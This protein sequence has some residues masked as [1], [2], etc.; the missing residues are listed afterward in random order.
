MDHYIDIKLMPDAEMPENVLMNK[1]Y[2]KLHKVL[3]DF[4]A[5]NIGVSFPEYRIKLG[6]LLRLHGDLAILN[7]LQGT[8]WLGGLGRGYCKVS[9]ILPVPIDAK[10]RTVSRKQTTM[11]Q[12][13]LRRLKARGSISSAAEEKAYIAKMFT[14]G[15]DN[16]YLE[17]ESGSNG[18]KHRRFIQFGELTDQPIA[19]KF[20][21]FGLSKLATIP[22]F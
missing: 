16:P 14:Q 10:H 11:S 8:D 17:L 22:W 1:V 6:K 9:S 21:H 3:F 12:A 2:T 20:D 18:H 19:G 13:K 15:I 7:D 4:N 5:D